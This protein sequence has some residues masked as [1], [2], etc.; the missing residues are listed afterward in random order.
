MI[1]R[2]F[3]ILGICLQLLSP[4]I[5]QEHPRLVE[6][7][8]VAPLTLSKTV[9]L[10]GTVEAR[11]SAT[12]YAQTAGVIEAIHVRAGA[13]VQR[14][15]LLASIDHDYPGKMHELS[16]ANEALAQKHYERSRGLE[17]KGFLS[18]RGL[19]ELERD[20]I[21]AQM[22][23]EQAKQLLERTYIRAP[24]EG[25]C[26]LFKLNAGAFAQKHDPVVTVYNPDEL[27]V[28]FDIPEQLISKI[29]IGQLVELQGTSGT[30][31]DVP[32]TID[33]VTHMGVA[34]AS[35]DAPDLL[36]GM[37]VYV[38]VLTDNKEQAL[39]LPNHAIFFEGGIPHVY[40]VQ[41]KKAQLKPIRT[42]LQAEQIVEVVS[43]IKEGDKV[44]LYGQAML[45]DQCPVKIHPQ[46]KVS[47]K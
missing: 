18:T 44:I 15:T 21:Q 23:A 32:Q 31:I 14:G 11:R 34:R 41:H 33:P 13:P 22:T 12:L 10:M 26:G 8:H 36:P 6:I 27:V 39:S 9:R 7:I 17:G 40:C 45:Y 20:W 3:L 30:I 4:L 25:V 37:S 29:K 42:G 1:I 43:G 2:R 47:K 19:E 5:A 28:T 35:I 16:I 46:Q 24:F 38:Q